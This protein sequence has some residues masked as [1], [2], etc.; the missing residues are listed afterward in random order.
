MIRKALLLLIPAALGLLIISQW[1][2]IRRYL[3][4]R[5]LSQGHGHP[6]N[7]PVGGTRAYPQHPGAGEQDGTGTSMRPA[8]E[9]RREDRSKIAR[10]SE[11]VAA[12]QVR[13][14]SA[15]WE[16]IRSGI[17]IRIPGDPA[18]VEAARAACPECPSATRQDSST[19]HS[20]PEASAMRA[21][22]PRT[23]STVV[24][25]PATCARSKADPPCR[26]AIPELMATRSAAMFRPLATMGAT[27][28]MA[29]LPPGP[30]ETPDGQLSQA[31][32]VARWCRSQISWTAVINGKCQ[33]G[34]P[35]E[36]AGRT[37]HRPGSRCRSWTGHHRMRR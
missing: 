14:L 23:N 13:R 12:W 10:R 20:S 15:S 7:V 19:A 27:R 3:K 37:G 30:A 28:S 18:S 36:R 16:L 35:Q 22:E 8:G 6:R 17:A 29:G 31:G 33:Q 11:P 21:K 24:R 9:A 5:Q 2:D 34:G 25:A 1:P 4:I 26:S 32:T